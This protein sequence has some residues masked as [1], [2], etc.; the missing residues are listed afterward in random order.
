MSYLDAALYLAGCSGFSTE[1]C[2]LSARS[3]KGKLQREASL[4]RSDFFDQPISG[5]EARALLR[6][7]AARGDPAALAGQEAGVLLDA[8]GGRIAEVADDA[9]AF[10][11]RQAKFLAQEFVTFRTATSAATI[12]ANR[13]WLN[14]LWRGLRPAASGF[15]YVNYIDPALPDWLDAYYGANL[16]R[17]VQVKRAYDP[18]GRFRS[19][20][21]IPTSMP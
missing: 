7:I 6:S 3:P 1:Q 4:A 12:A 11:H 8:W 5:A 17:L 16:P 21:G 10:P 2:Q 14:D 15:A 9:T 18:L 13:K 20:Q 19:P